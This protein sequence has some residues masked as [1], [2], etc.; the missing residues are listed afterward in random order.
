[1]RHVW[2]LEGRDIMQANDDFLVGVGQLAV[3]CSL[4]TALQQSAK[5]LWVHKTMKGD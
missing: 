5:S 4:S 2:L 3:Y 1:M